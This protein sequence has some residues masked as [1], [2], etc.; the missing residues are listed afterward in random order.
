MLK[1]T[2][3]KEKRG[4]TYLIAL[5]FSDKTEKEKA[6]AKAFLIQFVKE[7]IQKGLRD[8]YLAEIALCVAV[9]KIHHVSIYSNKRGDYGQFEY[10]YENRKHPYVRAVQTSFNHEAFMA[11]HERITR[12]DKR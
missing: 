10:H 7:G 1:K 5:T 9:D 3:L 11:C 2:A 8:A 4:Q 12:G 6:E